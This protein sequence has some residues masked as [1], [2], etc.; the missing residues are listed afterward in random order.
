MPIIAG[1]L[2]PAGSS[3]AVVDGIYVKG[4]VKNAADATAR[5]AI[6]ASRRTIGMLVKLD[7]DGSEHVLVGGI[8]NSDWRQWVKVGTASPEGTYYGIF[9]GQTYTQVASLGGSGA[10]VRMWVFNGTAGANTGWV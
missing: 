8:T 10:L 5:D 2:I 7:S 9:Q 6:P 3:F 4:G 1:E